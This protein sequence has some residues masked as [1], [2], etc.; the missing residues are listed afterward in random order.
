MVLCEEIVKD[1]FAKVPILSIQTKLR[2][3]AT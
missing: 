1:L 3:Y 2:N